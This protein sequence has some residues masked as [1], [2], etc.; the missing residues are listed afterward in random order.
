MNASSSPRPRGT[1][2]TGSK[3]RV[4]PDVRVDLQIRHESAR[5]HLYRRDRLTTLAHAICAEEEGAAEVE[6]SLV[7]CDDAFITELNRAYRG[8]DGPTDVLSFPQPRPEPGVTSVLGDIV[9]SLETIER[10]CCGD[11][12]AMRFEVLL[13][14]CHGVLHLLGYDHATA[15]ERDVMAALQARYLGVPIEEAWIT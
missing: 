15:A 12:A 7:F 6:L 3:R 8:V 5:K 10:R 11:R 9:I 13:L 2:G 4:P 1:E 14:F